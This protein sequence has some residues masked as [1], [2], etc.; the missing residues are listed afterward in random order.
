MPDVNLLIYAYNDRVKEYDSA[1][2]W[3]ESLLNGT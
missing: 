2:Q 3:W 1:R